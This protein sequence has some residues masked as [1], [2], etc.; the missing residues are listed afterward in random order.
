MGAMGKEKKLKEIAERY[1]A[2]ILLSLLI[3]VSYLAL[4]QGNLFIQSNM[5]TLLAFSLNRPLNIFSYMLAHFSLWHLVV[6]V[7]ILGF[8]GAV[9]EERLSGKDVLGIFLFAGFATAAFFSLLH[10]NTM[11]AGA[12]AGAFGIAACALVLDWKKSLK[13]LAI[14]LVLVLTAFLPVSTG[15]EEQETTLIEKSEELETVIEK[16]AE[17]GRQQVVETVSKEKEVVEKKIQNIQKGRRFA[18]AVQVD[19]FIHA[20]AAVFGIVYLLAFRRRQLREA[21][22]GLNLRL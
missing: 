12:S 1:K 3:S 11:L 8:F 6:N 4:S 9:V 17:E 15:I 10:P 7:V 14:V 18:S 19:P 2:S 22:K 16:A 21:A 13:V 5:I 20:Y